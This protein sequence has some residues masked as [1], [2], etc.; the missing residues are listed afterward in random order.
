MYKVN[1]G[2]RLLMGVLPYIVFV[3]KLESSKNTNKKGKFQEKKTKFT[4][5]QQ[6][7]EMKQ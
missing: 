4:L 5:H 1:K 6:T 3:E 7:M 2:V